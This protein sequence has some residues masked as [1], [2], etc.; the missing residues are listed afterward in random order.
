MSI[1]AL[2]PEDV[3]ELPVEQLKFEFESWYLESKLKKAINTEG[4]HQELVDSSACSDAAG[5][6]ISFLVVTANGF[7]GTETQ[8]SS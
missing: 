7:R 6:A 5:V 2:L 8:T 4:I 1:S 3:F